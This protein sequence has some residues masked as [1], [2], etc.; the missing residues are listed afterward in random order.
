MDS[1]RELYQE[2]IL[3]HGRHPRNAGVMDAP[4]CQ[5]DGYNPLCGDKI[6]LYLALEAGNIVD[7]KFDA[8]GCA[9]SVASASLMSEALKG[10]TLAE[11]HELFALFHA[12]VIDGAD[13]NEALGKLA[14]LAGV[15]TYPARVKCA[16]LA[17]HTLIAAVD[18]SD[19]E[20]TT[21]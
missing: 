20:V 21:E 17:W 3:D 11:A 8:N 4:S 19:K 1:M 12:A 16:T 9:I 18:N 14:V 7:I 2:L 10:K 15:K 6:T 13:N 5:K